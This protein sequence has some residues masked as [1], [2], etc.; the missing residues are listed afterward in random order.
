MIID[1]NNPNAIP[2]D[3]QMAGGATGDQGMDLL[4]LLSGYGGTQLGAKELLPALLLQGM[5]ASAQAD[6]GDPNAA[7]QGYGRGMMSVLGPAASAAQLPLLLQQQEVGDQDRML[8]ALTALSLMQ[9]RSAAAGLARAKTE[10]LP[11]Q[12]DRAERA[13]Q[14]KEDNMMERRSHNK[15]IEQQGRERVAQGEE[16]LGLERRRVNLDEYRADLQTQGLLTDALK[17]DLE[18]DKF[19][20]NKLMKEADVKLRKAGLSDKERRTRIAEA[21]QE[22]MTNIIKMRENKLQEDIKLTQA[23]IRQVEASDPAFA[24]QMALVRSLKP[25]ERPAAIKKMKLD[26]TL[27][28]K[29]GID[30]SPYK[31]YNPF[32][33]NERDLFMDEPGGAPPSPPTQ[34]Q[35]QVPA[36]NAADAAAD[37][38]IDRMLGGNK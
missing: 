12:E 36:P 2:A 4:S 29:Y 30:I 28:K 18:R 3:P 38:M 37:A 32:W 13:I 26:L 20:L 22:A 27:A 19:Q 11:A 15:E 7:I 31:D 21:R 35:V 8:K 24:Q 34:P 1:P 9:S 10:I 23:R 33:N 16:R 14:V 25:E 17:L 6:R 5:L